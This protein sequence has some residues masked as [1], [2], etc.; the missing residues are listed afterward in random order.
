MPNYSAIVVSQIIGQVP[1][2]VIL[3]LGIVLSAAWARRTGPAATFAIVGLSVMLL[4]SIARTAISASL[5]A[6]RSPSSTASLLSVVAMFRSFLS[7]AG[8]GLLLAGVFVGRPTTSQRGFDIET[9]TAVDSMR[10]R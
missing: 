9:A 6:S 5:I 7:A 2:L 1:M 4:S 10:M 3:V 8:L